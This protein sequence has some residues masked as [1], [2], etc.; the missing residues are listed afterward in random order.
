MYVLNV[1]KT[2]PILLALSFVVL[3]GCQTRVIDNSTLVEVEG[4]SFASEV[5]PIFQATC[6]GTGC[7]IGESVGGVDLT[8]YQATVNSISAS[9]NAPLVVAGNAAASPLVDKLL[10]TPQFGA[11]MP[12]GRPPLSAE[13]IAT[14]RA[15]V[16]EGAENN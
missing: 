1:V 7:H 14:I 5:L 8:S 6:G 16:D 12:D 9:Y 15:W 4:V 10:G 13:Q 3:V 11:R 2:Y